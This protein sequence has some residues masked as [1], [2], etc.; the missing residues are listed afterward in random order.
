MAKN[1]GTLE[2]RLGIRFRDPESERWYRFG[3]LL[4]AARQ[5]AELNPAG[6][7]IENLREEI[8]NVEEIVSL[9]TIDL[10]RLTESSP[11]GERGAGE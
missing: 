7:G 4:E 11:T 3:R 6:V 1:A 8:A 5:V 2:L 10:R 9:D